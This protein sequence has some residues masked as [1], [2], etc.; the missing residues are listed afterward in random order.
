MCSL[1]VRSLLTVR[2]IPAKITARHFWCRAERDHFLRCIKQ[3]ASSSTASAISCCA[4]DDDD[5]AFKGEYTCLHYY[6]FISKRR[7]RSKK[8]GPWFGLATSRFTENKTLGGS[9]LDLG[10][11]TKTSLARRVLFLPI[12]GITLCCGEEEAEAPNNARAI[13]SAYAP[14]SKFDAA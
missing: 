1:S 14:E 8:S 6:Y 13:R 3:A 10:R 2:R 11:H 4:D 5:D 7:S 12:V 9:W